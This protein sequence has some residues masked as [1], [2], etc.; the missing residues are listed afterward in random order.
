M[1]T[2]K[3]T[4]KE[5]LVGKVSHYF[6]QIDV[7]AINLTAPLAKGDTVRFEGGETDFTQEVSSM[8]KEHEEVEKAKKGDE[9]GMKVEEK[10][11]EGYR[12][13]KQ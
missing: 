10:V 12:V 4:T 9:I 3:P 6:S 8:Q 11:R 13:Y 7:A 2:K 5:K 1:P